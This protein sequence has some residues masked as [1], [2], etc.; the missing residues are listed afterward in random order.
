[1]KKNTIELPNSNLHLISS[2]HDVNGNKIIKL[3]F[4]DEKGF[5]IQT[6]G[7]LSKTGSILRGLKTFTDMKTVSKSELNVISK[8]VCSYIKNF[9]TAT[10]KR[11][12]RTY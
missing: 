6:G 12:L 2:G 5:S 9:G 1:M 8:E 7:N 11:K 10:Q 4:S 3:C